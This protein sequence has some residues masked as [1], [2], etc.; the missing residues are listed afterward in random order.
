MANEVAKSS[1]AIKV[2][3]GRDQIIRKA[4]E[5]YGLDAD[6]IADFIRDSLEVSAAG[7]HGREITGNTDIEYLRDQ[8][9]WN[10]ANVLL[11][12]LDLE[13]VTKPK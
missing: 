6:R 3:P 7:L 13:A 4:F 10:E 12:F 8:M 11:R 1:A 9:G 2:C 5:A